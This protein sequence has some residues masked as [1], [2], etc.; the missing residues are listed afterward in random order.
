MQWRRCRGAGASNQR[1]TPAMAAGKSAAAAPLA[2]K[3]GAE[4]VKSA[5]QSTKPLKKKGDDDDDDADDVKQAMSDLAKF[6]EAHG[7]ASDDD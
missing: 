4:Y 6:E 3:S 2:K 1:K 5:R 7:A